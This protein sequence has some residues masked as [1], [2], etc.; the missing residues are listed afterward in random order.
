MHPTKH[1]LPE[2]ARRAVAELL[3]VNLA[4][5]IDLAMQAKQ[6]HWNVKGPDFYALH[7]LFDEVAEGVQSSVDDV[8]ERIAQLGG[9]AEGTIGAVKARTRLPEYPL[10][11]TS[12]REHVHALRDSLAAYA[13]TVRASIDLANRRQVPV[14]RRGTS[15]G[16]EMTSIARV[17]PCEPRLPVSLRILLELGMIGLGRLGATPSERGGVLVRH[18]SR[19]SPGPVADPARSAPITVPRCRAHAGTCERFD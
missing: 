3:N 15:S 19:P 18:E 8:A 17:N 11:I 1:D 6:A 4:D 7:K 12:G 10:T 13:R 14:A 9:I 5:A 16:R 2:P